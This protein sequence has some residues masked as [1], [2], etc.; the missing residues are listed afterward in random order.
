MEIKYTSDGKKVVVI[1]QLNNQDKIVQE[2]FISNGAEIPAGDHFIAQS[3]LDTPMISW[4]EKQLKSLNDTFEKEQKKYEL[5][6]KSQRDKYNSLTQQLRQKLN[7]SASVLKNVNEKSFE[8]LVNILCGEIKFI[9][10]GNYTPELLTFEKFNHMYDGR[11]RLLSLF[12]ADDGS[13]TYKVN[14]YYDYS[15]SW[16]IYYP[17]TNYEDAFVKF[18]QIIQESSISDNI[19]KIAKEYNIELSKERLDE[20]NERKIKSINSKIIELEKELSINKTTLNDL[21]V[22]L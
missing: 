13:L 11:L 1:G 8:L 21:T 14:Q 20:F 18:T 7:Y 2:I 9:V 5:E 6:I 12:G 4:K 19:I 16:A 17:F 3:L 15:G 22:T 10:V